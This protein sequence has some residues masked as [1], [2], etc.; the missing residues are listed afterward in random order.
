[1]I[2]GLILLAFLAS[3]PIARGEGRIFYRA[4]DWL[5]TSPETQMLLLN[6]TLRA[7]QEVD[8]RCRASG[9]QWRG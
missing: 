4:Q 5:D 9:A 3:P 8:R 1:M 7:W 2:I 6:G